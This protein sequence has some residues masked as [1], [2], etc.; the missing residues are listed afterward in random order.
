[1]RIDVLAPFRRVQQWWNNGKEGQKQIRVAIAALIV[2]I[3]ALIPVFS[4]D[5]PDKKL[6]DLGYKITYPEFLRAIANKHSEAVDLFTRITP[7]M[8]L[9]QNDFI[10]L[11]GDRVFNAKVFAVLEDGGSIDQRLCPTDIQRL[12]VYSEI[13]N[14]PEKLSAISSVCGKPE[15]VSAIRA[16][17]I[18]EQNRIKEASAK[19]ANRPERLRAC[20][21]KYQTENRQELIE[22]AS[23]F[24]LLKYDRY[25]ERQCVLANLSKELLLGGQSLLGPN[26]TFDEVYRRC[27]EDYD[28]LVISNSTGVQAADDAILILEGKKS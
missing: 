10:G 27:C 20:Q 11:F 1:M 23:K 16:S 13:R 2:A 9:E 12:S 5:P 14:N 7:K 15:V 19:N 26:D 8:R 21:A 24:P 28:P 4:V 25:T 17:R 18:A 3:I 22:E 6:S